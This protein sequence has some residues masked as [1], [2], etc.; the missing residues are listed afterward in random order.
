MDLPEVLQELDRLDKFSPKFPDKLVSLLSK[1][2]HK[3][4]IQWLRDEDVSWLVEYLDNVCL[5]IS[6]YPFSAQPT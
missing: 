5:R 6:L 1:E 3:D 4:Y 2:G